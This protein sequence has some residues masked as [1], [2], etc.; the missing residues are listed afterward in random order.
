MTLMMTLMMHSLRAANRGHPSQMAGMA[1]A[2]L[3]H[4]IFGIIRLV[5]GT[6]ILYENPILKRFLFRSISHSNN[7]CVKSG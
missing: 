3:I 4:G 5:S 6:S 7:Q 1:S 2:K